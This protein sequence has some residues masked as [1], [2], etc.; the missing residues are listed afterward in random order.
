MSGNLLTS[1]YQLDE[2][3]SL[4]EDDIALGSQGERKP[5]HFQQ[6]FRERIRHSAGGGVGPNYK[7]DTR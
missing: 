7:M 4:D 3:A 2:S 5:R 1:Q 6:I